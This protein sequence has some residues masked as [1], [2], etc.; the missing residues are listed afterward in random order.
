MREMRRA[1]VVLVRSFWGIF[2]P[3]SIAYNRPENKQKLWNQAREG[4]KEL[5]VR[6][7]RRRENG[8]SRGQ[9]SSRRRGVHASATH[10]RAEGKE[11]GV[12]QARSRWSSSL[13]SESASAR[14]SFEPTFLTNLTS[15]SLL[16]LISSFQHGVVLDAVTQF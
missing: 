14:R 5:Q 1:L 3:R 2:N 8:R 7:Y 16:F 9:Y 6:V 11:E 15:L 12:W 13:L 4:I 10:R